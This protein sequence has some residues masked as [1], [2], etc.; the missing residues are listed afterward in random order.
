LP[1]ASVVV[2][3]V[4]GAGCYGH[5]GADDVAFD[6]ARLAQSAGGRPVRVQW[7]RADELAWAPFGAAMAVD[8]EADLDA[9]GSIIDWRHALWSNGHSSRPGRAKTPALLGSW[10]LGKPYARPSAIN[11][12]LVAGGGAE[13]NAIPLYAFPAWTIVNHRVLAAPLRTS[14]LR[15]LGA[16]A[17]V[18]A[19]ESFVDELAAATA[20]DP[21]QFR[22]R[23]LED[24]RARTV[25]ESAAAKARW[26]D[27]R[28][29]EGSGHGIAFARY[30]N[31]GAYCAVVAEVEAGREIRVRR[32]AV[33]VDVGLVINPDGVANQIEGG[34]VQ[35]ASWTLK[36]AVRFD[37]TR[38]TSDSWERYPIL[39]FSEVPD[40][41]VQIIARPDC[42][43]L[44]AGEA[45]MGPTAAAIGNAVFDALGVRVRDLPITA[46]RIVAAAG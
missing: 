25:L 29:R 33:V 42:P 13:R 43:P 39:R 4:E 19:I 37:R 41:D 26:H 14:A 34:A 10:H 31:S 30:K 44:G 22:L 16:Y 24:P 8:L 32:L 28:R 27:W 46:L 21:L 17:N 35:A 11:P 9:G 7:S 40:V 2:R 20:V 23:Y 5:N 15:S 45:P 36:E 38:V 3:H 18:Y 1:K 6:A 12:S